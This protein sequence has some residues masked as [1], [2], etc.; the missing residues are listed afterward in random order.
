[1][2]QKILLAAVFFIASSMLAAQPQI[3]LEVFAEDLNNPAT[4]NHTNDSRLFVVEQQGAIKIVDAS[5]NVAPNPFLDISDRVKYGGEQGLLGLAFHPAYSENGFFY[6]NYTG[7]SDSTHIARFS[8]SD[9]DPDSAD[10][11]S[12]TTLLTFEQPYT[13]HNG[14]EIRFGPDGYLYIATGDGGS[15]GDPENRAQDVTTLLG[16]ILRI[17]VD[18]PSPYGIPGENPFVDQQEARNEIWALG[19]RNPWR[20]SFDSETGDLWI[21]DVGQNQYEEINREPANSNGGVNYGWR[22][23]EGNHEFNTTGCQDEEFYTFPVHEYSHNATGGCSVTGGFVYRGAEYPQMTGMYFYSDYCNDK[24]YA[25][26]HDDGDW[27]PVEHGQFSGNN[28]STFGEDANGELYVAGISSGTIYKLIDT[29][30]TATE[31]VAFRD[32]ASV[33]PNPF[34]EVIKIRLKTNSAK[35]FLYDMHGIE[36][37]K[38]SSKNKII[39]L[40]TIDLKPGIYLLNI[41]TEEGNYTKKLLK[42]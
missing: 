37:C 17:D 42:H 6:V 11:D 18:G 3:D 9:D 40:K 39:N 29:N 24:I 27:E 28:F 13:N 19:L 2:K 8:V 12:E 10:P 1:M 7:Q 25:L 33:Q 26:V 20:F 14:G 36:Q 15:G 41:R 38:A 21:A 30:T 5:G 23:Y 32:V 4:I 31:E 22:C 35:A 16:K 34:S